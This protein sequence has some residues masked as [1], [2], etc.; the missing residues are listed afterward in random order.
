MSSVYVDGVTPL[1]AE[2]MNALE[3]VARKGVANGYAGLDAN[4]KVP[5]AQLLVGAVTSVGDVVISSDTGAT[6]VGDII[7]STKGVERGRIRNAGD[8]LFKF[9]VALNGGGFTPNYDTALWIAPSVRANPTLNFQGLYI[10]ARVSGDLGGFVHDAGAS[11]LRLSGATNGG[12]GQNAFEA[13]LVVT[14]GANTIASA[15]AILANFHTETTPSGSFTSVALMRASA[16]PALTGTFTIGTAYG[17]YIEQQA[18]AATNYSLYIAG[19]DSVIQGQVRPS[20]ISTAGLIIRALP[21]QGTAQPMFAIQNST[22]TTLFQLSSSGTGGIGG[23]V[24]STSFWINNNNT[25]P[26]IVNL[27]LRTLGAQTADVLQVQD[28]GNSNVVVARINK[29]G[30]FVTAK[31]IAPADAD[32]ANSELAFW[33]DD[34]IGATKAMF[35]AKDSAGTVR[36]GSVALT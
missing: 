19:G 26:S 34:T 11:E 31:K 3:Q 27:A 35:K 29:A 8:L 17:I 21:S 10:Q 12:V 2:R 23:V 18:V 30:Y 24:S 22:P 9:N 5:A 20:S 6:G 32:L 25:S 7:I 36:T 28:G 13:S 33:V 16:I 14:G 1:N 4:G 15:N